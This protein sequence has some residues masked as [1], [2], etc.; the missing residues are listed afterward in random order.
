MHR[1]VKLIQSLIKEIEDLKLD[2][3][4]RPELPQLTIKYEAWY[5][6]ALRM[7]QNLVPERLEDFVSAYKNSRS[8]PVGS[9][10]YT[11]Q[12]HLLGIKVN[13]SSR[14]EYDSTVLFRSLVLRQVGILSS[15]LKPKPVS[16]GAQED[17]LQAESYNRA[18]DQAQK[19]FEGGKSHP[20]GVLAANVLEIYLR[21]QWRKRNIKVEEKGFSM[22]EINDFLYKFRAYYHTTYIR[23]QGLIPIAEACL[24]PRKKTPSKREIGELI[25]ALRK[26]L[27]PG[28]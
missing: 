27:G 7:V 19:L 28:H 11:I 1:P 9:S 10:N 17:G 24:D 15:L 22:A 14:A 13:R 12:D 3:P 25:S 5:T 20:A 6:N 18:L 4:D 16:V 8:G 2:G 21:W 26:V 23:V